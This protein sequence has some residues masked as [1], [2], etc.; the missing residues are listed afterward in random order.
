M[1]KI[2]V[3]IHKLTSEAYEAIKKLQPKVVIVMDPTPQWIR[4]IKAVCPC[5]R[6]VRKYEDGVYFA[7]RDP[8]EWADE[9][10]AMCGDALYLV[11]GAITYNE[12]LPEGH[13]NHSTFPI[14][15]AWQ[16]KVINRLQDVHGIDALAFAFG[17]GQFTAALDR[18]NVAEAFPKSSKVCRKIAPHDYGWP[19]MWKD[20][21]WHSLRW[22]AWLSDIE[23]A[24]FGKKKAVV[25]ECGLTHAVIQGQPDDGWWT[26][27]DNLMIAADLYL[28]SLDWYDEKLA[29]ISDC[30]GCAPFDWAG[31]DFGWGTFEHLVPYLIEGIKRIDHGNG[32]NG[33]GE[34][35]VIDRDYQERTLEWAQQEYGISFRRATCLSGQ[36]VW[37][38][39]ELDEVSG[40]V[41]H[42]TKAVDENGN[43]MENV[44]VAF[45]WPTAPDPAD[46]PTVV[47]P[48]DWY[49]NFVHGLT[50]VN[51]DIGPGM[52]G[53]AAVGRGE[54]GPHK[55]WVRGEYPSDIVECI[56]WRALTPHDH[57]NIK[58]MLT[59][60]EGPEPPP[61]GGES[62]WKEVSRTF[63]A[64]D[65]RIILHC[66]GGDLFNTRG[67]M[68]CGGWQLP[69]AIEPTEGGIFTFD[70]TYPE[71]EDR[72]YTAW[73]FQLPSNERVSDEV[74]CEFSPSH[75]GRYDIFLE[76][77][78]DGGEEPEPPEGDVAEQIIGHANEIIRLVSSSQLS[79]IAEVHLVTAAGAKSIFVPKISSFL[80]RI[81]GR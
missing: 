69:D 70:T 56:G 10:A 50:N 2:G 53:G 72:T 1:N 47:T 9:I 81:F 7:D 44:D 78:E 54:C 38:L 13:D 63:T 71:A 6:G 26:L 35:K 21:G 58:M 14:F 22:L 79:E 46:P 68:K 65:S 25:S 52:G 60:G 8:I 16:E 23:N 77:G 55:V 43:P 80:A 27:H 51:G 28:E 76:W 49:R 41:S 4:D 36:K 12:P 15:D 32:G 59:D 73:V 61:N 64:G 37:R 17:T 30:I 11:D 45:Y 33:M 19:N 40:P 34:I 5:Y 42:I 31:S 74:A 39:V 18:V 48:L 67:D 29:N 66:S 3:H 62:M 24:G 57:L 75:K 20:E